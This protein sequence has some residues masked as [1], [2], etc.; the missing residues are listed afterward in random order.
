MLI[1][2]P[3]Y[4]S[5]VRWGKENAGVAEVVEAESPT[6][7]RRALERLA[8]DPAL[9]LKLATRSIA[10]G[11]QYFSYETVTQTFFAALCAR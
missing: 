5:A 6:A 10:L 11:R 4:C 8:H 1:N 7:L 9:R 3:V 2:G